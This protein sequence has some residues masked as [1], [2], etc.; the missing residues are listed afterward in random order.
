MTLEQSKKLIQWA[1]K[2]GISRIKVTGM[3]V[4]FFPSQPEPMNLDPK[5][6]AEALSDSMPDDETMLY[7]SSEGIPKE[8]E[9][10]Q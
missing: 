4:E 9:D 5:S 2:Q 6:L 1:K 7:A 10:L 8:Q 3:E